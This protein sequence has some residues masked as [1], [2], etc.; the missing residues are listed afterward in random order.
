[1]PIWQKIHSKEKQNHAVSAMS[2]IVEG[3]VFCC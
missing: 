2:D 3:M 1:M